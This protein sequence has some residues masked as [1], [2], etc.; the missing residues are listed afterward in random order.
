MKYWRD[1]NKTERKKAVKLMEKTIPKNIKDKT[2]RLEHAIV[3]CHIAYYPESM[4]YI[5]NYK[6]LKGKKKCSKLTKKK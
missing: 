4:D 1:L 6:D 3:N 5:I 2:M